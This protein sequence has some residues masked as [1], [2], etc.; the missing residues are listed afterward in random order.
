MATEEKKENQPY[1][2]TRRAAK[3]F[4]EI[5]RSPRRP[6][7][8]VGEQPPAMSAAE[9]DP[10][11]KTL[12]GQSG[13][14]TEPQ[15][16]PGTVGGRPAHPDSVAGPGAASQSSKPTDSSPGAKGE[17]AEPSIG[18]LFSKLVKMSPQEKIRIEKDSIGSLFKKYISKR[19]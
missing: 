16:E 8:G 11:G 3:I 15:K 1:E 9:G 12:A 4:D 17:G 2:E 14:P 18:A 5:A 6:V 10:D 13:K 19:G 7:Q